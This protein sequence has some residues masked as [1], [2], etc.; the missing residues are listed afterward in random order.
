MSLCNFHIFN[1][2]K[3]DNVLDDNAD[4]QLED[5]VHAHSPAER[6][7]FMRW[8]MGIIGI[9]NSP[10]SIYEPHH[11]AWHDIGSHMYMTFV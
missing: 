1:F 2:L 10:L 8:H 4:D 5:E 11:L 3:H 9:H 7:I 6:T